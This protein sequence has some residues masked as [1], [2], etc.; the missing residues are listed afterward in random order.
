MK[1]AHFSDCH[2]GG[3]KEPKLRELGLRSFRKAMQECI[4]EYVGFILIAGDLFDT[5]LPSMDVVKEVTAIFREVKEHDI[6]VYV[7]PG[8]HDYSPSGKTMIDV[9]EKAG[10]VEN[11]A[12]QQFTVDRTGIKIIGVH[13]RKGALEREDYEHLNKKVLEDEAGCKIFL[14]HTLLE[15]LKPSM[16]QHVAGLSLAHLPR[17]FQY[18]AGGH[19]HFQH[20]QSFADYGTVAYPGP[21]FPNN[22]KE[23]EELRC[24]RYMVVELGDKV[25]V[26]HRSIPLIETCSFTFRADGKTPALLEREIKETIKDYAQKI[27]TMRIEGAVEEGIGINW[28]ALQAHFADAYV[29]LKNTTK[30]TKKAYQEVQVDRDQSIGVMEENLIAVKNKE[31]K[32]HLRVRELMRLLD[33]E[34]QEGERNIDYESRII[35]ETRAVL[36]LE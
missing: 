31:L 22:F 8:S 9:F 11:V 4:Q 33:T 1:F 6:P 16:F 17:G 25:N 20:S 35:K 19:P 10:L 24:G 18:Y 15:E 30:L 27:V 26:Q 14:F 36:D 23:L 28:N 29:L 34:K 2:L 5:A 3:W 32:D 13:G 21:T 7:I 12:K